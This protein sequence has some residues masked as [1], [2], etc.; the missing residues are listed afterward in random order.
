LF[1][2]IK[3]F[4]VYKGYLIPKEPTKAPNVEKFYYLQLK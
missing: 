4:T 1:S 2:K 3:N